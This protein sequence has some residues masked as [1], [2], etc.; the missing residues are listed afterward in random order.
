MSYSQELM[1]AKF[2]VQDDQ[3]PLQAPATPPTGV[4]LPTEPKRAS[5]LQLF[6][7]IATVMVLLIV[8]ASAAYI[9]LDMDFSSK[10]K[11]SRSRKNKSGNPFLSAIMRAN[12]M[13]EMD[14]QAKFDE[15]V[16]ALN[17]AR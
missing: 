15:V 10:K 16:E 2:L 13:D 3:Q 11:D 9:F 14:V 1:T 6:N 7:T 4:Q 17:D 12:G 8:S 5:K